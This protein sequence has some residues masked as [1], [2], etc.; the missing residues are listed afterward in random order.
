MPR[1]LALSAYVVMSVLTDKPGAV[2]SVYPYPY[3]VRCSA[4]Q[5]AGI[6]PPPNDRSYMT[7]KGDI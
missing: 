3:I 2:E 1:E 4:V 6:L 7:V 5:L